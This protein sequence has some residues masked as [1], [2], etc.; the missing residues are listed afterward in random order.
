ME[1]PDDI[2]CHRIVKDLPD[3][4]RRFLAEQIRSWELLKRHCTMVESALTRTLDYDYCTIRLQHNPLR[5]ASTTAQFDDATIAKRPCFLCDKNRPPEQKSL[6]IDGGFKMLCNPFPILPE[7]FTVVHQQHRPQRILDGLD[8]M[9]DLSQT[10]G[11][12]FVVFYNGPQCGASAPD[13]LHLQAARR[14]VMP[15]DR[16]YAHISQDDSRLRRF[17][18][19]EASDRDSAHRRFVDFYKAFQVLQPQRVEP[20]MNVICSHESGNWRLIIFPRRAHRPEL[21]LEPEHSK[22][23]LSPGTI[24]MGGIVI[25]PVERDFERITLE[26]IEQMYQQVTL[27]S[28]LFRKLGEAFTS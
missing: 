23:L 8:A 22:L 16:E 7:H 26:H 17:V 19:I 21:Y 6:P 12:E 28:E 10:L 20:M 5:I 27:E 18:I 14:G 11:P 4:V 2:L 15:I 13:H 24:D 3:Q 25:L 1:S 9:L